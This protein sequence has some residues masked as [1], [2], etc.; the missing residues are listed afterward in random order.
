MFLTV[1]GSLMHCNSLFVFRSNLVYYTDSDCNSG[2]NISVM[3]KI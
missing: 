3:S 1:N 2:L